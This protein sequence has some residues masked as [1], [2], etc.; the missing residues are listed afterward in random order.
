MNQISVRFKYT[1]KMCGVTGV[2][3]VGGSKD[4]EMC[5][6]LLYCW[7]V[8]RDARLFAMGRQVDLFTAVKLWSTAPLDQGNRR[9]SKKAV[10]TQQRR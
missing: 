6:L 7:L 1:G 8:Y 10:E 2:A 5:N 3:V 9:A 4:A